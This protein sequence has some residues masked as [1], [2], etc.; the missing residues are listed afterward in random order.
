MKL[1]IS[2]KLLLANFGIT[3]LLVLS[4][5]ALAF[6]VN[7]SLLTQLALEVDASALDGL[8]QALAEDHRD[9]GSWDHLISDRASWQKMATKQLFNTEPFKG[10]AGNPGFPPLK[11]DWPGAPPEAFPPSAHFKGPPNFSTFMQRVELL[12]ASKNTL[13][14]PDVISDEHLIRPITGGGKTLGWARVGILDIPADYLSDLFFE[15]QLTLIAWALIIGALLAVVFSFILS[16]HFTAPIRILAKGASAL[17]RR[18]FNTRITVNTGDEL[19]DLAHSFNE[20]SDALRSYETRQKQWIMDISHELRTPLTIL[21]GEL[22]AIKDGV[23]QFDPATAASLQEEGYQIKRLVDDLHE[24]SILE[25]TDFNYAKVPM[26][27]N[28]LISNQV[29]RYQNKMEERDLDI[30]FQPIDDDPIVMGDKNR[31]LQV[32]QN[33]IEN[34]LRYV[35]TPGRIYISGSIIENKVEL[36]FEDTG[37]GVSSDALPKLFDRLYRTDTSR[38]RKTGGLGLGLAICKNIV[39]A[40]DGTLSAQHSSKGGLCINIELSLVTGDQFDKENTSG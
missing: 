11:P 30:H 38:S 17:A 27:I 2:I 15:R 32:F 39:E 26:S 19:Q 31:L 34:C 35:S 37:P 4:L 22:E 10:M 7:K 9:K 8:A 21:L 25:S 16:R 36:L 18:D 29:L 6:L 3:M 5:L 40:H 13:I 24:L 14:P 23:S 28:D 20:I 12:D 33:I 1:K